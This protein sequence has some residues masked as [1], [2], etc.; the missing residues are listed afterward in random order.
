MYNNV[1]LLRIH[2]KLFCINIKNQNYSQNE[3]NKW[4]AMYM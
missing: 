1:Q 3:L 2:F 4:K